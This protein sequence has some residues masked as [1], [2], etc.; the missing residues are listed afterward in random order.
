LFTE[1]RERENEGAKVTGFLWTKL[2]LILYKWTKLPMPHRGCRMG[3]A[4]W[5]WLCIITPYFFYHSLLAIISHSLV[6]QILDMT[7]I[8]VPLPSFQQGH[9]IISK[10][11]IC[12]NAKFTFIV[13][14]DG[15]A[16][17]IIKIALHSLYLCTFSLHLG[18][19]LCILFLYYQV[20]SK[21]LGP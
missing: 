2:P 19:V 20:N 13:Q 21:S 16:V 15:C 9:N 6:R 14:S 4:T 8:S 12:I 11:T 18:F 10:I 5:G 7:Q 1:D 3:F 17:P